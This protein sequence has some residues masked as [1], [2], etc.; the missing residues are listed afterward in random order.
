MEA[1]RRFIQRRKDMPTFL[2]IKLQPKRNDI[3]HAN[4]TYEFSC[5]HEFCSHRNIGETERGEDSYK[6]RRT[7][8]KKVNPGPGE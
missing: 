8:S 3:Y 6:K 2:K 1:R 5:I 7:K 4:V